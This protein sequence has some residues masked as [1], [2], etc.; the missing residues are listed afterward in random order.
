M[1]L[2]QNFNIDNGL[3]ESLDNS[4]RF[5]EGVHIPTY[6]IFKDEQAFQIEEDSYVNDYLVPVVEYKITVNK[7]SLQR[8]QMEWKQLFKIHYEQTLINP[9]NWGSILLDLYTREGILE[10]FKNY[11]LS[12]IYKLKSEAIEIQQNKLND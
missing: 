7:E 9:S 8:H 6:N 5:P 2:F 12:P 4:E 11:L 1:T 3:K 10:K